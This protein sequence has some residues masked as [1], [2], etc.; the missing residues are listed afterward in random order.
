MAKGLYCDVHRLGYEDE[1][2]R[3]TFFDDKPFNLHF[4]V[5]LSKKDT[6][7]LIEELKK[8]LESENSKNLQ[9]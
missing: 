8:E 6:E 5:Q 4:E 7:K 1:G 9:E 2:I 3:L